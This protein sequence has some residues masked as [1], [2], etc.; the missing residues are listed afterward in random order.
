MLIPY[1]ELPDETLH[2]VARE[3]VVSQLAETESLPDLSTWTDNVLTKIKC[4]DLLIEFSEE[5]QTVYL[6][7]KTEIN[8]T[9]EPDL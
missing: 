7:N 3:W 9:E 5:T 2:S 1:T 4:G 6:K 8:F